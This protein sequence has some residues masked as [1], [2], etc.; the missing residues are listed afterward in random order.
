MPSTAI[1]WAGPAE[2]V[3]E[4][5]P[6]RPRAAGYL[7]VASQ[8]KAEAAITSGRFRDE[9]VPVT[10]KGRK[11][12]TVVDTDEFPRFGATVDAI[13]KLRPGLRQG[14]H[15]DRR[16]R[17]GH[18]RRRRRGGADDRQGG[19]APRLLEPLARIVSW[20]HAGVD[21]SIM[22]TGPIPAS[23]KALE[24][25]GSACWRPRSGRGQRGFRG[26]ALRRQ[27]G[28]RLGHRQGQRQWRRDRARP[29]DR[30]LRHPRLRH[31][32]ARD[33]QARRQEGLATLSSAAGWASPCASP[34]TD[35]QA[36]RP[37]PPRRRCSLRLCPCPGSAACSWRRRRPGA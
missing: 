21:P 10:I 5:Y 14:R 17:L 9:I 32:A 29:S 18:Q 30:R 3:A 16:Q 2:N 13:A 33:D 31:P 25:A 15:G 7:R 6:D 26:P 34:A 37:A 28:P 1:T 4:K 12:D 19:G 23:R 24:R 36:S 20:A 27:Q 11:G 22:G 35:P 8:N